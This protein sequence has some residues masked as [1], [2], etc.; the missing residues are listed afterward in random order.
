MLKL[1]NETIYQK[2]IVLVKEVYVTYG[3]YVHS[4]LFGVLKCNFGAFMI[5]QR[6][7]GLRIFQQWGK[8]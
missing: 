4:G 6:R 7:W 3:L 5:E 1:E 8:F 2:F